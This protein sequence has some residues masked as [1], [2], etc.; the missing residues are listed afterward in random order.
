MCL[1]WF[2]VWVC[3]LGLVWIFCMGWC[4]GVLGGIGFVSFWWLFVVVKF[5]CLVFVGLLGCWC[6]LGCFVVVVVL[7]WRFF[8]FWGCWCWFFYFCWKRWSWLCCFKFW[9]YL[10]F[11]EFFGVFFFGV[12]ICRWRLFVVFFLVCIGL[13]RLDVGC[14]F[15]WSVVE[16]F[17]GWLV[18][19]VEL[20]CI[21]LLVCIVGGWGFSGL[22]VVFV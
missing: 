14:W 1:F 19:V 7:V 12:G 15:G 18:L 22:I 2:L 3:G 4:G 10:V 21:W 17:W 6:I 16:W 9:W 13:C 20:L 8:V 11:C 5:C